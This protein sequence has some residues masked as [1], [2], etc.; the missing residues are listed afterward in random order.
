MLAN[1][2]RTGR[3]G[4]GKFL[5]PPLTQ[6]VRRKFRRK[7]VMNYQEQE[8]QAKS[9]YQAG[10]QKVKSTPAPKGQ[11]FP[12]GAR[13]KIAD[14]L[15]PSMSHFPSGKMATVLY[16]Y[17]HAYWGDD[18]TSYCLDVDGVGSVAWYHELQLEH[19]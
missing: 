17:A 6:T 15:G 8:A 14:D 2:V 7:V 10:L 19:A 3:R 16:T 13:V 9:I 4:T 12:V 5:T 1:I 18:V 11:K